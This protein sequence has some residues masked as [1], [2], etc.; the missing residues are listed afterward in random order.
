MYTG[1]DVY[2][3]DM[4]EVCGIYYTNNLNKKT[5][6]FVTA[7]YYCSCISTLKNRRKSQGRIPFAYSDWVLPLWLFMQE[8]NVS[9]E[10]PA[11]GSLCASLG[12]DFPCSGLG[13]KERQNFPRDLGHSVA[14][15]NCW[16]RKALQSLLVKQH[17]VSCKIL[18]KS[19]YCVA[20]CHLFS[21]EQQSAQSR[22]ELKSMLH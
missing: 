7:I 20:V 2:I 11:Q 14:C 18:S 16:S 22:L 3:C 12:R 21:L 13:E 1:C 10:V 5:L 6:L 9:R 19:P 15:P 4:R 17:F 8:A